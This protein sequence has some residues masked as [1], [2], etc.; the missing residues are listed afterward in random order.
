MSLFD[1]FSFAAQYIQEHGLQIGRFYGDNTKHK[2]QWRPRACV[3]GAL[4]FVTQGEENR[5]LYVKACG[6]LRKF[7][8]LEAGVSLARWSDTSDGKDEVVAA[9]VG[10]ATQLVE[11]LSVPTVS[12]E[13]S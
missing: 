6:V 2:G 1:T 9:L 8:S 4:L 10:C 3:L 7:L 11:S 12:E 5:H 13:Q